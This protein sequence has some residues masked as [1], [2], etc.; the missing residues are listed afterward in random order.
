MKDPAGV[1]SSFASGKCGWFYYNSTEKLEK[2]LFDH[3]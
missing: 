2:V 3:L 1:N